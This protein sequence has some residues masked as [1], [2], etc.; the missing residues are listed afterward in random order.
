[1]AVLGNYT[2]EELDAVSEE[3]HRIGKKMFSHKR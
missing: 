1:M 2:S 3:V